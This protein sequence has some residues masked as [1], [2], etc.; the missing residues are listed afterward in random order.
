MEKE[1]AKRFAENQKKMEV[2]RKADKI[3]KRDLR[4]S[5]KN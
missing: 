4:T 2:S 3:I 5:R 1:N